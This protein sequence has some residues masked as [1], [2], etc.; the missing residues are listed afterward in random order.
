MDDL[1]S[2]KRTRSHIRS[3]EGLK[4]RFRGLQ[5]VHFTV[6][7]YILLFS[8]FNSSFNFYFFFLNIFKVFVF[9]VVCYTLVYVLLDEYKIVAK[10][11]EPEARNKISRGKW[12]FALIEASKV[13]IPSCIILLIMN[14]TNFVAGIENRFIENNPGALSPFSYSPNIIEGVLI[15]VIILLSLIMIFTAPYWSVA[16]FFTITGYLHDKKVVKAKGKPF[17]FALLFQ[18]LP[19]ILFTI[20]LDRMF[21]EIKHGDIYSH[22]G[23]LFNLLE[24]RAYIALI[25]QASLLLVLNLIYFFDGWRLMKKREN[26]V[27]SDY[28]KVITKE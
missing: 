6:F 15:G 4:Q 22:W 26:F 28:L 21:V 18:L 17:I 27:D 23:N 9:V 11:M 19:L 25:I 3:K 24:G 13:F 5:S 16:R 7:I 14:L 8:I 12:L 10:W 1:A 20:V 2:P